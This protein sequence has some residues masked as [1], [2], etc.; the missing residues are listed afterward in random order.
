MSVGKH[1]DLDFQRLSA[2]RA[3]EIEREKEI[4]LLG[5]LFTLSNI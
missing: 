1:D 4:L 2:E 5:E 3:K